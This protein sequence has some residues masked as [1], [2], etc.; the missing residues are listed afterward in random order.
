L[1]LSFGVRGDRKNP[2]GERILASEISGNSCLGDRVVSC[3]AAEDGGGGVE[4][5]PLI[6]DSDFF[7][8]DEDL[9]G[10]IFAARK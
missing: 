6:F 1:L 8:L 3:R 9:N 7:N 4:S 10:L 5:L 2:H